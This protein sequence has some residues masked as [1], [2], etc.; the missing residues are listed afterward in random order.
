MRSQTNNTTAQPESSQTEQSGATGGEVQD[1][2]AVWEKFNRRFGNLLKHPHASFT[3]KPCSR[4]KNE[5]EEME[6][7]IRQVLEDTRAKSAADS[8][9]AVAVEGP[10]KVDRTGTASGEA[11]DTVGETVKGK[12][13]DGVAGR[14]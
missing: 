6:K 14:E 11:D 12:E 8:A 9:H 2:T 5:R 3:P 13:A 7:R 10:Q 4:W 1:M